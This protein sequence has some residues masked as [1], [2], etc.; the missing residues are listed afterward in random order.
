MMSEDLS[1]QDIPTKEAKNSHYENKQLL[2]S[3]LQVLRNIRSKVNKESDPKYLFVAYDQA[4]QMADLILGDCG[5]NELSTNRENLKKTIQENASLL[6]M[7]TDYTSTTYSFPPNYS[8]GNLYRIG[9][10][11]RQLLDEA[12]RVQFTSQ[13]DAVKNVSRGFLKTDNQLIENDLQDL[14]GKYTR[15]IAPLSGGLIAA[16]MWKRV[17]K[18]VTNGDFKPVVLG[19]SVDADN[20]K[21]YF[22]SDGSIV[23]DD[24]IKHVYF[25]DDTVHT[26]NTMRVLSERAKAHYLN[27]KLYVGQSL[28]N[29]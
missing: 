15:I 28:L 2:T 29:L 6:Q 20:K 13:L 5:I 7:E 1:S 12:N 3:G 17:V 14:M 10:Q 8:I 22:Q 23:S 9:E 16:L 24:L 19:A 11:F 4:S 21:A 27:A 25:V 18:I 26:G